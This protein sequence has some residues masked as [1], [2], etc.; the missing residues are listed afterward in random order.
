MAGKQGRKSNGEGHIRQR[1]NGLWEA[2]ITLEGGKLKS[3]YG[4]TKAEAVKKQRDA[5]HALD[6]G[7]SL[8]QNERQTL[9]QFLPY[10]LDVKKPHLKSSTWLRYRVFAVNHLIPALGRV[11]LVKLTPQH[12]QHLYAAKLEAGWSS[13]T[14]HHLSHDDSWRAGASL[15]LVAGR[16]ERRRSGRCSAALRRRWIACLVDPPHG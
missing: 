9:G 16:A 13:T 10:W 11:Q 6:R 4:K 12:L 5:L 2:M 7:Q 3:F 15:A 14:A 8:T 1:P